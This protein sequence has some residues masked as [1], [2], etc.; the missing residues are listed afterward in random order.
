MAQNKNERKQSLWDK[1]HEME[2]MFEL[3]PGFSFNSDSKVKLYD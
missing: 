2:P 3:V 1:A